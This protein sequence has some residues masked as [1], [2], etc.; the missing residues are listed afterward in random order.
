MANRVALKAAP[1]LKTGRSSAIKTRKG[2]LVPGILYGAKE[3]QPLEVNRIALALALNASTSKYI[4][5]ELDIENQRKCL[6]VLQ[7]VQKDPLKDTVTHVDFHEVAEDQKIHIEVPV[8]EI[9]EPIGVKSGGGVLDHA[10]RTLKIECLPKNIPSKFEVDVSGLDI[11]QAIHVGQIPM[12]TG[13][14]VLNQKD[15]TVFAVHIPKVVEE[16][17]P[18]TAETQQPEVINEKKPEEGEA[19][20]ASGDKGKASAGDKAAPPAKGAAPA[21]DKGSSD[22]GKEK[23]K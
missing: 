22:K 6:A 3:P 18:A 2:G 16:I 1:R 4:L 13:V 19:T 21:A 10:L 7:E 23:K 5:V 9:G 14:T 8:I 20:P 12:P 17:A 15:L 11:G